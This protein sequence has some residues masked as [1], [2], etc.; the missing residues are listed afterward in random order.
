LFQ[1]LKLNYDEP[2]SS[3]GFS[4]NL[5]RYTTVASSESEHQVTCGVCF[6]EFPATGV[7]HVGC[8]HS[9]CGDCWKGYLDNALSDG[10]AVL[11]LRCP[12]AG[13]DR[14]FPFRLSASLKL[15]F[16]CTRL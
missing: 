11:N 4:C 16:P 7:N 15:M 3:V 6:D 12:Q 9:F 8:G 14:V 1:N 13:P 5:R 10:P 2:L